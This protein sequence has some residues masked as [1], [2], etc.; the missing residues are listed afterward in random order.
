MTGL[1][2]F[3]SYYGSKG[4]A[5]KHYPAPDYATIVEPFAGSAGY[6]LLYAD[7]K[8]I[9]CD[10]DPVIAAIW[11]YLIRVTP[12]EILAIPDA[13][14]D[15]SV[16][17]IRVC[18]EAKWLVG[19]WLNCGTASP[20]KRPSAWMR[21]GTRPGSF[22]GSRVRETIASQLAAIRH[23]EVREVSY[24]DCLSPTLATWFVDPPY[25]AGGQHYR[26]GPK[27]IDYA[28]LAEW[29]QTRPGQTIVCEREG[30]T[31]LPFRFLA[32]MQTTRKDA[33]LREAVWLSTE[34]E[35]DLKLSGGTV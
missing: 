24:V 20:C 6:S 33:R 4:S 3:F 19:F 11:R 29:C 14:L 25:V 8:V 12:E 15:G 31:W 35:S 30:S 1:R 5:A 7:R 22:W 16:D 17:D 28:A 32:D 21:S 27:G 34:H 13:A 9:L 26:A 10:V 2:K 23:W 18:Q